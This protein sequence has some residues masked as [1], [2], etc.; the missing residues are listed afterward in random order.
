MPF[1]N[2][3]QI[4]PGEQKRPPLLTMVMTYF[5]MRGKKRGSLIAEES[6]VQWALVPLR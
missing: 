4:T 3:L 5:E 1:N 2:L 6:C